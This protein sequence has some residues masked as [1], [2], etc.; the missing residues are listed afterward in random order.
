M[1]FY[2]TNYIRMDLKERIPDFSK[3][4]SSYT[5]CL[6]TVPCPQIGGYFEEKINTVI[7]QYSNSAEMVV[8]PR[9]NNNHHRLKMH[10]HVFQST[11]TVNYGSK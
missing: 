11:S 3:S 6:L 5:E 4:K 9:I 10:F 1:P 7:P 2:I 8:I